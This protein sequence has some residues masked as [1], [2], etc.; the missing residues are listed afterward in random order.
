MNV[1]PQIVASI[2]EIRKTVTDPNL[3]ARIQRALETKVSGFVEQNRSIDLILPGFPAKS[4]DIKK[5]VFGPHVDRG[6]EIAVA[7]LNGLCAHIGTLYKQGAHVTICS[8]GRI[9]SNELG[10][11]DRDVDL[12]HNGLRELA[13]QAPHLRFVRLDDTFG[14]GTADQLRARFL[15]RYALL[16]EEYAEFALTDTQAQASVAFFTKLFGKKQKERALEVSRRSVAYYAMMDDVYRH[17][18]RLSIH[19]Q[20]P[21]VTP[22]SINLVSPFDGTLTPWRSVLVQ[23]SQ[24]NRLMLKA[25]AEKQNYELIYKDGRPY[26]FMESQKQVG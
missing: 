25:D 14:K 1:V 26:C 22:I 9:F 7:T 6:E 10:I 15:A 13:K 11:P 16:K 4:P 21:D 24:G 23:T 17:H 2:N 19:P 5:D 3:E 18:I 20:I 8:D 12:Y